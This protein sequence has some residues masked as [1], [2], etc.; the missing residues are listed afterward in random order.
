MLYAIAALLVLIADQ[1]LK[2]YVTLNIPLGE[3]VV[4]LIP[5]VISLVNYHNTGAAFSMLSGGQARWAFVVLAVGFTA[6]VIYM[7]AHRTIKSKYMRWT[8][9][10]IAA[11][12]LGNAIDRALYGYVVDMFRTDFVNFAIFNIADIFIT[13]GGIALCLLILLDPGEKKTETKSRKRKTSGEGEEDEDNEDSD[14]ESDLSEEAEPVKER[15]R[16]H[17]FSQ[18]RRLPE[19]VLHRRKTGRLYG[20]PKPLDQKDPLAEF[21]EMPSVLTV[22]KHEPT[23]DEVIKAIREEEAAERVAAQLQEDMSLDSILD[24]CSD[25]DI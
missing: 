24:E 3:G 4:P 8:L 19:E 22:D 13:L 1:A 21:E 15:T 2:Y 12:A 20:D 18:K 25:G 23:A 10:L 16:I 9:V 11:G 14:E 7:L 6:V 5:H 17:L